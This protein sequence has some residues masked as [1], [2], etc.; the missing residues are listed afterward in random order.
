VNLELAD[1]SKWHSNPGSIDRR[2]S[3]EFS[4]EPIAAD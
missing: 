4:V 1:L 3:K 2:L